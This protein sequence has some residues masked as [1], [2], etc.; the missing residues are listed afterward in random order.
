M[1]HF[2]S[3]VCFLMAGA[4]V[5]MA[6]GPGNFYGG[7]VGRLAVHNPIPKW[8]GRAWFLGFAVVMFYLGI[9]ALH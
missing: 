5:Y 1:K 8:F 9:K 2:D 4:G 6:L 7:G 3:V